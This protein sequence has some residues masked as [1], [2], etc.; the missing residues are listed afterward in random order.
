VVSASVSGESLDGYFRPEPLK[1]VA[2]QHISS[3]STSALH[4]GRT[5]RGECLN[6]GGSRLVDLE[7]NTVAV[8]SISSDSPAVRIAGRCPDSSPGLRRK[9]GKIVPRP[10]IQVGSRRLGPVPAVVFRA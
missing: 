3:R 5:F 2:D 10:K 1:K 4:H 9:G 6:G 8:P 7:F